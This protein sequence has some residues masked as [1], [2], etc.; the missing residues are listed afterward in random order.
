MADDHGA[1]GEI[2]QRILQRAQG[3]DIQV[4]GRLVKQQDIAAILEQPRH[5]HPVAFAARQKRYLLL[6]IAALEVERRAIGARVHL[7]IAKLDDV[8]TVGNRLP[9]VVIRRQIVARLI[10]VR[11][12]DRIAIFDRARIRGL[13]PGEGFEQRRFPGTV[14][15]DHP[16][17]APRRQ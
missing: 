5:M 4:V 1:A 13:L 15:P 16:D 17:N 9:D 8:L 3:F 12:L 11:K 6:L 10:D 2:H 14:R 7:G